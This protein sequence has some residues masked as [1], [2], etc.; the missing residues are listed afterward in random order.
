[1]N[2]KQL[3][4]SNTQLTF[5]SVIVVLHNMMITTIQEPI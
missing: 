5:T 1:M 2:V 3:F 4:S